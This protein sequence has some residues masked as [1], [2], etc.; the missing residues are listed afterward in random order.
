MRTLFFVIFFI[1]TTYIYSQHSPWG[2]AAH[3]T[4][5]KEW[6]NIELLIK[7][8][9]DA[10]IKWIREDFRFSYI[11]QDKDSY[12]FSRY[13][14]L[15]DIAGKNGIDI[16]PILQAYD[17]EIG[18]NRSELV[19]I[20]KH[21]E[22]WRK[23]VRETVK[24]YHHKL[25]YWEIW[26]EQDGGFWKPAPNVAQYVSLL[27]IAYE[28][29]KAIDM[30]CKVIVGGLCSWNGDYLQAMYN[31]GAKGYFDIVA[32]HPYNFGP[33]VNL[34]MRRKRYELL[35][36]I[37]KH[38]TKNIPVWITEFGGTSFS[39]ELFIQQ[40]RF[41]E[42]AIRFALDK[43]K[44]ESR[45]LKIGVAI[46][47]RVTN[48]KEVETTRA[49]LP[50]IKLTPVS[51]DKLK[52]LD[53]ADCPAL[54]G[55]ESLYIDEPM[56]APLRK[57]VEKGGLLIAVNKLPFYTVLYEDNKGTWHQKD[58]A[59]I[60]YPLF[61]MNFEAFW[62][63]KG[64]PE[65]TNTVRLSS[66]AQ[67]KGLPSIS[68]IYVDRFVDDKNIK[69]DDRYYPIIRAYNK[70]KLIGDGMALYT[71]RDWKGGVLISTISVETGYT[72]EEQANLLQRVYLVYMSLGVEKM[73]WYDLHNDG[74]LKG[75]REHNFGLLNYDFSPKKA[76]DAYKHLTEM[77]GKNPRFVRKV[78]GSDSNIWALIF[79]NTE[80][81]RLI[82]AA[83]SI[84]DTGQ[85]EIIGN[86]NKYQVSL[87]NK[88]VA[89]I[90]IADT[91]TVNF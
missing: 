68:N 19:P 91:T 21:P 22:V 70:D 63:K 14:S 12:R 66:I 59:N 64:V 72:E 33:D 40:P 50:D 1:L 4:S 55:G 88:K 36:V 46:S 60:T 23:Y 8:V 75:E 51:F 67:E 47:P 3:P 71:Y 83:W 48:I 81:H 29:I 84:T 74:Q 16:L 78:E 30:E 9:K 52:E 17:N 56:L 85:I 61:R 6:D 53:P 7:R 11:C 90:P 73:F 65:H 86:D 10:N 20:Y 34:M 45:E 31:E 89:F 58:N 76:Y 42:N 69:D 80:E 13:D 35:D 54:I 77:L 57:Y 87:N 41:M 28:E 49:W 27:K 2:V 82:L 18:K 25:K 32:V 62:T 79:E 38:E 43:L 24:R 37:K 26:N 44:K 15:V 5:N 39:G